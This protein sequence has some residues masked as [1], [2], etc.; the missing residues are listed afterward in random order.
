MHKL[1]S[2]MLQAPSLRPLQH[3]NQ[4]WHP[5]IASDTSNISQA[6]GKVVTHAVTLSACKACGLKLATELE[7]QWQALA[8]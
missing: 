1:L 8:I 4:S 2:G 7:L 5:L 3:P 6:V